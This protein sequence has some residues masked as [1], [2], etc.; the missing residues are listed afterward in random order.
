[1]E[2]RLQKLLIA[3]KLTP[4]KLADTLGV[5]RSAISHILSGRNKPSFDLLQRLNNKFPRI[6]IEWLLSGKGNMYKMPIQSSLFDLNTNENASIK[7]EK[8]TF[9]INDTDVN[10]SNEDKKNNSLQK[11]IIK[12]S[13]IDTVVTCIESIAV[14]Y[15]NG[16]FKIYQSSK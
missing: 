1:M 12:Q 5:Q 3:E 15:K 7:E 14:F 13:A 9:Q 2:G 4:A 8:I 6:S 10:D 16:T 11:E